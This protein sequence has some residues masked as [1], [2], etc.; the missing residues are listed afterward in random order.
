MRGEE[1]GARGSRDITS[2]MEDPFITVLRGRGKEVGRGWVSCLYDEV[3]TVGLLW[4]RTNGKW[5]ERIPL[6]KVR[7]SL[8]STGFL[9]CGGGVRLREEY[10]GCTTRPSSPGDRDGGRDPFPES[11]KRVLLSVQY[12]FLESSRDVYLIEINFFLHTHNFDSYNIK[13]PNVIV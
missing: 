13:D 7:S 5:V 1:R 6:F 10:F 9:V 2:L 4:P 3:H 12:S 8:Q 11:F